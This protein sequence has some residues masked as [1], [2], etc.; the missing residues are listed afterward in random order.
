MLSG[1]SLVTAVV[2]GVIVFALGY[3]Y[4][5]FVGARGNLKGAR[6]AV[7]GAQKAFWSS[8]RAL[9]KYGFITLIA[10]ALLLGWVAR[11]LGNAAES[12]PAPSPAV[13][14]AKPRR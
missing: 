14:S 3:F 6:D 2:V 8:L 13:S 4:R 1:V 5:G 9:I 7:P 12:K 10:A 11:D